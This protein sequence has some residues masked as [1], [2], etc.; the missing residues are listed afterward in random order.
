MSQLVFEI[1][2]IGF[3]HGLMQA[4]L[5]IGDLAKQA[6]VLGVVL[7][8]F[9]ILL[10]FL[11]NEL[12]KK[13]VLAGITGIVLA[14]IVLYLTAGLRSDYGHTGRTELERS[15]DEL[16][17]SSRLSDSVRR[18][19]GPSS[20]IFLSAAPSPQGHRYLALNSLGCYA[21]TPE[22][23]VKGL[24]ADLDLTFPIRASDGSGAAEVAV[25]NLISLGV[26]DNPVRVTEAR[27]HYFKLLA[28]AGHRLIGF[29]EHGVISD[30]AGELWLYQYGE[31]DSTEPER[32]QWVNYADAR[33]MW[34]RFAENVRGSLHTTLGPPARC[35]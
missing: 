21:T 15:G 28:V 24:T 12:S 17:K 8:G 22:S 3:S 13:V 35:P 11:A 6:L 7:V 31:G 2:W 20:A 29:A 5:V 9:G 4:A 30:G 32:T 16:R 26:T 10:H 34:T 14:F 19:W 33:R 1:V 25:G 27:P 18:R 23:V